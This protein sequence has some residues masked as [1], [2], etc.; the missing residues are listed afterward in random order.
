MVLVEAKRRMT[1]RERN[2]KNQRELML[3]EAGKWVK[4]SEDVQCAGVSSSRRDGP[5]CKSKWNLLIAEYKRIV[6][7]NSRAESPDVTYWTVDAD[8]RKAQ[9]LPRSFPYE[10]FHHVNS[11]N[12][13][14]PTIQ[15]PHT[16]DTLSP[17]DGNFEGGTSSPV[18]PPLTGSGDRAFDSF[19]DDDMDSDGAAMHVEEIMSSPQSPAVNS[20]RPAS[21]GRVF[22]TAARNASPARR[23]VVPAGVTPVT[24]TSSDTSDCAL[25]PRPGNTAV[26]RTSMSGHSLIAEATRATGD[27]LATQMKE[28]ATVTHALERSKLDVQERFHS[29]H[30]QYQMK[31]DQ[32]LHEQADKSLEKQGELVQCLAQ[33]SGAITMGFQMR[34][35]HAREDLPPRQLRSIAQT[36]AVDV[37][38]AGTVDT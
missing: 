3:P 16:R 25:H 17:H 35:V 32:R 5:S 2:A 20:R 38:A 7:F 1:M 6:D 8:Q 9:G 23:P 34:H 10:V 21:S 27:A 12:K 22:T 14:R 15:P 33:L 36:Q 24:I 28:M 18:R 31:R 4:I 19:D 29:E 11:W 13:D 26:R 30:M 37:A